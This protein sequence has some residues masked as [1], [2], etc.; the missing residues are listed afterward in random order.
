[1]IKEFLDTPIELQTRQIYQLANAKIQ[2]HGRSDE[3]KEGKKQ[4]KNTKLSSIS[5]TRIHT[6]ND[7]KIKQQEYE[8]LY[9]QKQSKLDIT[10]IFSLE[11]KHS[12]LYHTITQK[13]KRSNAN[14]AIGDA[15][16]TQEHGILLTIRT[17]DCLPLFIIIESH[18][19]AHLIAAVH[20]GWR[21]L[22]ANIIGQVIQ[23]IFKLFQKQHDWQKCR[24][25][26][27]V[28]PHAS[29][30]H[31]EVGTEFQKYFS[32]NKNAIQK[33]HNHYY[34]N[35]AHIAH[36][37]IYSTL[38][39]EA[40]KRN[41]APTQLLKNWQHITT[42]QACTISKN[43]HYFSHRCGDVGRNLNTIILL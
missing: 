29:E 40:Q 33:Y 22:R 14:Y 39:I 23:H 5:N 34:L 30:K 18:E 3:K 43:T 12:S 17:A 24:I 13:N 37:Q 32:N 38:S 25:Y 16:I 20:A 28:G 27:L 4:T 26:S 2:I 41:L 31:Y 36:T 9:L 11:Q 1:M 7:N 21:G 15:L 8:R 35:M 42:L 6:K 19:Q 10:N